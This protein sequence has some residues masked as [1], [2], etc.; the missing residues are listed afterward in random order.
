MGGYNMSGLKREKIELIKNIDEVNNGA[1][2][3][4]EKVWTV[5]FISL[6]TS[7][8]AVNLYQKVID[9]ESDA[10]E[11]DRNDQ[12]IDLLCEKVFGGKITKDDIYNRLPGAGFNDGMSGQEV[13]MHLLI[14]TGNGEQTDDTKN[15]IA[16]KK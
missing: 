6:G 4:V 5:P 10:S 15:F 16:G 14:F 1:E 11:N 8:E 12:V 9:P 2:V 3:E 13:L 7:I